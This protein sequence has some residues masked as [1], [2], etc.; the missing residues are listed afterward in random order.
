MATLTYA[1]E[2]EPPDG[3]LS[4]RHMQLWLK[5]LR[6]LLPPTRPIRFFGCGEYGDETFRPHYHV[7][8]YGVAPLETELVQSSWGMG[9]VHLMELNAETAQYL[10][11]YVVK[12]MTS[13]D[14][15]RLQGKHPEFTRMSLRPHG[16]GAGAVPQSPRS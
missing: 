11:G 16:I 7:A 3:S 15:P 9:H 1:P 4:P 8:L 10:C 12:K 14:D 6:R 5:R 13:P 2:H